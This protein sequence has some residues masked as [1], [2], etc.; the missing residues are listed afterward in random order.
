MKK[1]YMLFIFIGYSFCFFADAQITLT[2]QWDHRYGGI[3]GDYCTAFKKTADGFILAGKTSSDSSGNKMSH[4]LP[5]SD[6]DY[7]VVK[8]S[9]SGNLIWEKDFQAAGNDNLWSI[10]LTSD[11]GYIIGGT[12]TSTTGPVKSDVCRGG[13][14][15]WIIKLD[16][17]GNVMWDKTF[18]G[19]NDDDLRYVFQTSDGGYM[20]GGT[21]K[22]DS[23]WD[24]TKPRYGFNDFWIVKTDALGNKLWDMVYGGPSSEA[25]KISVQTSDGGYL[26]AGQSSSGVG[27]TK[28]DVSQ[29]GIDYYLVKTDAIGNVQWD[30][31]YGGSGDDNLATMIQTSTGGFIVGGWTTSDVSGD[32]TQPSN[33]Q[34]DFWIVNLNSAG[35]ILWEKDFGGVGIEDEFSSLYQTRDNGFLLGAT[36]YS[37]MGADKTE[38]NLGVEQPWIIKID[39]AGNKLWDKTILTLG[40]DEIGMVEEMSENC[41]IVV[42]GDN[43]LTGGDKSE[44][45]W[46]GFSDDFWIVKYCEDENLG[47]GEATI[48]NNNIK[49]FPIPFSDDLSIRL[50]SFINSKASAIIYDAIG[51]RI[52]SKEFVDEITLSTIT[53]NKGI[54]IL[55][56]TVDGVSV[57][58]KIIK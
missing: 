37:H 10:N 20:V 44:D 58:K 11:G 52:L 13:T 49:I 54:Y 1:V 33:G 15:Y 4:M 36:S 31:A 46:G 35:G 41:Y 21:S 34:Y 57:R 32:K 26:H 48:N 2:K 24:K 23:V 27:G 42:S 43:G 5:N 22:S 16:D 7:W 14:D 30:S 17:Q 3:G 56:L 12:S 18:G 40:H 29:G 25:Y 50:P 6:F 53:L 9:S 19:T 28:T 38:N 51:K 8:L 45:A 47:T 39:Q 55:E